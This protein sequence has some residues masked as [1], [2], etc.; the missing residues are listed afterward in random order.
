MDV[1]ILPTLEG[2]RFNDLYDSLKLIKIPKMKKSN[3]PPRSKSVAFGYVLKRI[4]RNFRLSS[5]SLKYFD[6]YMDLKALI[7]NIDPDFSYTSIQVNH[8]VI[9]NPHKDKNNIGRSV[10]VS[11]GDYT[12][13]NLVIEDKIYDTY[14]QPICF[15]GSKLT[16][17]N[18]NDISGDKYSIV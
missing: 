10:I 1:E 18:T 16:H 8:N 15:D 5:I 12:G 17:W 2:K 7:N 3:L 9:C 11:L 13:S 14:H 4:G 6:I